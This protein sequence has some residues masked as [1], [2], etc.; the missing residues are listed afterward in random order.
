MA[1][2]GV[3]RKQSWEYDQGQ[4]VRENQFQTLLWFLVPTNASQLIVMERKLFC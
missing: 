4:G 3:I 2:E 1:A